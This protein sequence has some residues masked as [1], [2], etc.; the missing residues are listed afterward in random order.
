MVRPE[1]IQHNHVSLNYYLAC[2][3]T[4][5]RLH[6]YRTLNK[7]THALQMRISIQGLQYMDNLANSNYI[8]E[9]KRPRPPSL[10]DLSIPL[11]LYGHLVQS[12]QTVTGMSTQFEVRQELQ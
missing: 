1:D 6:C 4:N 2:S 3:N 12:G 9:T 7:D 10:L 8:T 11:I 5:V